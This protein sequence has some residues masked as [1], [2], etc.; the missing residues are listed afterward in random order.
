LTIKFYEKL[1]Y[2]KFLRWIA[3]EN[4]YNRG[5]AGGVVG[6]SRN[7]ATTLA[8]LLV[9]A[10]AAAQ[11][12]GVSQ[13]VYDPR[14][15]DQRPGD[16]PSERTPG[17]VR[18][19]LPM[20]KL[21]LP[22]AP[23]ADPT[24]LF[25]LRHISVVGA[26]AISPGHLAT[27]CQSYIGR[28]VSQAD[29]V[30]IAAAIS[31]IYRNAGFHLSRAI[32]PPQDIDNGTIRIQVI[33][34][35]ITA[36]DL[37]GEGA[38]D[39]GVRQMLAPLLDEHPSRLSTLERK[40]L[41]TNTRPGMRVEDTA[42]EE[43]G[44]TSG[45]FRLTV[46]VKA[47]HV[48]ASLGI[49][50]LGSS[51]VGPWQTYATVAYNSLSRPGDMLAVNLSTTPNDPRELAFTRLSY[52]L[53][54][55][56]D[57]VRVGASAY[58]SDVW[59]GDYRHAFADTTT[60][61]G[62]QL[63]A[64]IVPLQSQRAS[65]TVTTALDLTNA[66]ESDIFGQIYNDRVRTF[67]LT[68]DSRLQDK[69]GGNNYLTVTWREGLNVLGAS[70]AGDDF[71]SHLG[72]SPSF[73]VISAWF[74]RYQTLTDAWSLKIAGA[75][76][77]ASRPLYLS[78]QF[79][80][81][82]AAFGRGYGAAETSGDNGMAGTLERRF[83]QKLNSKYMSGYQLYSFVDSG[84]AWNSGFSYSDGISLVSVGGGVRF[85]LA[86]NTQ[87]DLSVAAPLSYHV[88]DNPGHDVRALF[89]LTSALELCPTNASTRGFKT[90]D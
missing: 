44:T 46:L 25:V 85:F 22:T 3:I 59:P 1:M 56:N 74:T 65:L 78:Q 63:R 32:V 6:P 38:E 50:N 42:L 2:L 61:E 76:Q 14:Q 41:L 33:E 12:Q 18:P 66:S 62:L 58:Y 13:P 48:Y 34:G 55:G 5:T 21:S 73:S 40:L 53:P 36:V 47:W 17:S 54:I 39:F 57:G 51:S 87:A 86:N 70:P 90:K 8:A 10:P 23:A 4:F 19:N 26:T 28:K 88:P 31:D 82:G 15:F 89:S 71:I 69:F 7:L 84:V 83:D 60:T 68:A 37:K 43:I 24:P 11:A 75:G 79:Y 20:P 35:N 27:A 67:S 16:E 49:D 64:S 45:H 52:D 72:A 9:L 29:L 30:E 81:G 80:L 77:M